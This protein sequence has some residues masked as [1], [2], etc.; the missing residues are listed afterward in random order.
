MNW[1]DIKNLLN[2]IINM[3]S[4]KNLTLLEIKVNKGDFDIYHNFIKSILSMKL[5]KIIVDIFINPQKKYLYRKHDSYSN[6][7]LQKINP[8]FDQSQYEE[9]HISKLND[10]Y[11]E[12]FL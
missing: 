4:L 3:P 9:L 7:E 12:F 1:E 8:D 2:N 6:E 5:K 11:I 10:S